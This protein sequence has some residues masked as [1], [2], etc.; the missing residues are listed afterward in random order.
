MEADTRVRP[1][2][3]TGTAAHEVESVVVPPCAHGGRD[4]RPNGVAPGNGNRGRDGGRSE[5]A[6][7]SRP[8]RTSTRRRR[9]RARSQPCSRARRR[10]VSRERARRLETDWSG[11]RSRARASTGTTCTAL[12]RARIELWLQRRS[13]VGKRVRLCCA[14]CSGKRRH[15]A[16]GQPTRGFATVAKV[17]SGHPKSRGRARSSFERQQV[18]PAQLPSLFSR[19]H[20][21]RARQPPHGHTLS[22]DDTHACANPSAKAYQRGGEM[23]IRAARRTTTPP[24]DVTPDERVERGTISASACTNRRDRGQ[25]PPPRRRGNTSAGVMPAHRAAMDEQDSLAR[26]ARARDSRRSRRAGTRGRAPEGRAIELHR[27]VAE[28]APSAPE[29]RAE[30]VEHDPARAISGE[31]RSTRARCASGPNK[32]A[33][34]RV[35]V[36]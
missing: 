8:A 4:V 9:G 7:I 20:T 25:G 35:A 10:R 18:A 14:I 27:S 17:S 11:I 5:P 29:R 19:S 24:D 15:S 28:L 12:R 34:R 33:G 13:R 32:F 1:A 26:G 2:V 16:W 30:A 22:P 36:V 6:A 3:G 31:G 21:P 23:R